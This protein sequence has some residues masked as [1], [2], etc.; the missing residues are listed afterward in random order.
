MFTVV[1]TVLCLREERKQRVFEN[2]VL[3]K[4]FGPKDEITG[5]SRRLRNKEFYAVCS[6]PNTMRMIKSKILRWAEH[7]ARMR[8][9]RSSCRILVENLRDRRHLEDPGVNGRIILKW[10]LEKWDGGINWID[11]TWDWDR[12]RPFVN[13]VMNFRIP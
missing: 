1:C 10:F 13:A 12:W 6:S 9:R 4:V 5:E 3:I 2:G 11:L 8:E 7:V